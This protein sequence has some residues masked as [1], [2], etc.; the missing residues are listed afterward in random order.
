M[1]DRPGR[2]AHE[3]IQRRRRARSRPWNLRG[4]RAWLAWSAH[5]QGD[6]LD[7]LQINLQVLA[8]LLEDGEPKP[9]S[10]FVRV[11]TIKVA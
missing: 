4:L 9:E 8:T 3:G 1:F 6:T 7:E 11:Q 2:L 5:T 10:A